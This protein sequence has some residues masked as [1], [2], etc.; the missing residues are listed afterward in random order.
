[1]SAKRALIY[2]SFSLDMPLKIYFFSFPSEYLGTL[3]G[4][5]WTVAGVVIFMQYGLIKLT[6]DV[7][8][9]WRVSSSLF[10]H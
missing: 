4:V 2:F 3:V 9:S 6:E 7:P 10:K 5:M 8:K 1:M